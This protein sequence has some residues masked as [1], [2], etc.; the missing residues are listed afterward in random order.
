MRA[1]RVWATVVCC[2]FIATVGCGA[3]F[4]GGAPAGFAGVDYGV[5][6]RPSPDGGGQRAARRDDNLDDA[7]PQMGNGRPLSTPELVQ[8]GNSFLQMGLSAKASMP[9]LGETEMD[10]AAGCYGRAIQLSRESY[11]ATLGM[12]IV[13]L[14]RAQTAVEAKQTVD[15]E[16]SLKAA[17]QMLGAAYM[18]RRG[19]FEPLFYLAWVLVLEEKYGEAKS[20]LDELKAGNYRPGAVDL[21]YGYILEEAGNDD[22]ADVSYNAVIREGWPDEA[23]EFARKKIK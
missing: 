14:T 13:H 16:T 5:C 8:H 23:V 7:Q 11:E 15:A 9:M 1:N 17:K 3:M 19:A 6:A 2:T 4:G 12:G 10:A 20:I 18:M 22:D 21:L